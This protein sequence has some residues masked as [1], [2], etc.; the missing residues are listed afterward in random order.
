M[1]T[2]NKKKV[3]NTAT[4]TQATAKLPT[5]ENLLAIYNATCKHIDDLQ[6]LNRKNSSKLNAKK[7]ET[8]CKRLEKVKTAINSVGLITE[9]NV[10]TVGERIAVKAL[11]TCYQKSG[12]QFIYKL[13]C[14]LVGDITERKNK[15]TAILSDGYDIAQTATAFLCGF[16]GKTLDD[17]TTDGQ[18]DKDGNPITIKR[19]TFR[20]VNRYIMGERQ[21][22][23]KRQYVD[24]VDPNGE[25]L[26]YEIPTE[27][28][29]P[30]ATDFRKVAELLETLKLSINEKKFLGYRLR[31]Y[32][33][34]T[35]AQ[36]MGVA[37]GTVNKYR[38]RIVEKAEKIDLKPRTKRE[39]RIA[40]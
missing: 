9:W 34:D 5:P 29:I 30:T 19:A 35:I 38:Q 36:K 23:F 16:L 15:A 39:K 31:G 14:D 1:N 3:A 2:E 26:Y 12:Q 6:A 27:W 20:A 10:Q 7:L 11:K 22:D 13:Y 33:L 4:A 17:K 21:H 25:T 28:D 8:A 37:R 18:T 24:D 32:S 40:K